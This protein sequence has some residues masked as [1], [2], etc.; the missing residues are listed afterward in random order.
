MF[1]SHEVMLS[2][3]FAESRARLASLGRGGWLRG[4]SERAY[5]EGLD[6]L[7]GSGP[8]AAVLGASRLVRVQLLKPVPRAGSLLLPLR[9]EA[10]GMAG[11]LFAVLDADLRLSP[12]GEERSTL[13]LAGAYRPPLGS[14][15]TT[16]D[17]VLVGQA[18][19]ATVRSLVTQV[20]ASMAAGD[21]SAASRREGSRAGCRPVAGQPGR[22]VPPDP[23]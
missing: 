10:T 15:D 20:A 13:A 8:C 23:G 21:S 5:A 4:P 7:T 12:G 9:W 18:A 1:A 6:R 19:A 11:R 14:V 22:K 2:M 16:P 3:S 17:R